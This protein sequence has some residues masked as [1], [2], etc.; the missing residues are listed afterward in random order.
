MDPVRL[1]Q[2]RLVIWVVLAALVLLLAPRMIDGV[3]VAGYETAL[4]VAV[5]YVLLS[6][7]ARMLTRLPVALFSLLRGRPSLRLL[8]WAVPVAINAAILAVLASLL[9][10]FELGGWIS[11]LV[12]GL[13]LRAI[14]LALDA[15]ER[16]R[17]RPLF[18]W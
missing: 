9:A 17:T 13:A 2:L 6:V 5:L 16:P 1:R 15:L 14:E 12:V 4:V 10:S 8:L 7:G 3:R 18:R 11:A